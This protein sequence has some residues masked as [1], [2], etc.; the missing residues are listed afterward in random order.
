MV[1]AESGS[2]LWPQ[3]ARRALGGRRSAKRDRKLPFRYAR[4]GPWVIVERDE[5]PG[6]VVYDARHE[7]ALVHDVSAQRPGVTA[8]LSARLATTTPLSGRWHMAR[9]ARF[10]LVRMPELAE[11]RF[12]LFDLEADPGELRDVSAEH[13]EVATRLPSS[14]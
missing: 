2:A 10:K 14:T 11:V 5:D 12:E 7:P 8:D 1:F 13:P 4:E 3:N 9:D 6:P